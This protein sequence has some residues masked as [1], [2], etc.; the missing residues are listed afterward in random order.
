MITI[1][2]FGPEMGRLGNQIFQFGLLFSLNKSKGYQIHL[3]L[4]NK[5][6]FWN[7]FNIK[8]IQI[9]N[10]IK[11]DNL[12][13]CIEKNGAC[14]FDESILQAEDNTIFHGHF[15]SYRY[16]DMYK[17]EL[18]E[19]LEFKKEIKEDGDIELLK[20]KNP[21]SLHIRRTD[22]LNIPNFG[23]LIETGYYEIATQYIDTNRD[24]LVFT[25]DISFAK[26]YFKDRK[27]FHIINKNEYVSLYMMTK[28]SSH[29]IANSTFSWMGAYL[30]GKDNITCPYTWWRS[31]FPAPNNIQKDIVKENWNKINVF[32]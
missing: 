15:Q 5:C 26:F 21:I 20:F 10:Y 18:L 27:N 6:Q 13:V 2:F 25:D 30:S 12:N 28:C 9:F 14:N 3:P 7:C 29:I 31:T 4:N 16:F 17:K 32:S 8:N 24:V 11:K 22:Y 19:T 23:N 1:N